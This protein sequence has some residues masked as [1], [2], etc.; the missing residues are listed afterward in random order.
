ML[1]T[2]GLAMMPL[3][4]QGKT[5]SPG[6]K[7]PWFDP[8][9]ADL[10]A[11]EKQEKGL[12]AEAR[13][14][15]SNARTVNGMPVSGLPTHAGKF[16]EEV[17]GLIRSGGIVGASLAI[18]VDHRLV[19]TRGYGHLCS[20]D[21]V[22]AKPT[23]P[24]FIGSITKTLCAMAGLTLVQAG[25]LGLDKKVV[26]ILPLPPL[27]KPGE[28]RQPEI[29]RVTVRMLME[30]TSG[31]F[32]VVE[33]LF[34]CPYY[35]KLGEVG[36]LELVHGDISQYDLVRRGM[37][38]PF[39]SKPGVEFNY[40]G[41]GLQVLGRIVESL[42]GLRLDQYISEKVLAPLG[43]KRHVSMSYLPPEQLAL[44]DA[45]KASKTDT[46]IPSPYVEAAGRC[47]SWAF[48]EPLENL[49]GNHW[50][51]ADACGA[52]MLSAVDL[53]RF[54]SSCSKLVHKDLWTAS[55]TP[56]V[57][58]GKDGKRG[59]DQHGLVWGVSTNAGH[60][61]FGHGGAWS[62]IRAFCESTWDDV[63]YAIV[64]SCDVD[65]AFNKLQEH[66]VQF[67]RSLKKQKAVDLWKSYGV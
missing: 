39:V 55:L 44:I 42:S 15:Q 47:S 57:V 40:S 35:G 13:E 58:R 43:V 59:P 8:N 27:L 52:S 37:A 46:F 9:Y 14:A 21:R 63:Q 51:Q 49:Y 11:R 45:G 5:P 53:L 1:G 38:K 25:K 67:G 28:V 32:N 4:G 3:I 10:P 26:D 29:D 64:A 2:A 22:H 65:D 24:G 17:A 6:Q 62:G 34:D 50:G 19:L 41:Q 48:A 16:D 33:E 54:V 30:H 66:V 61:Q 12:D 36:L 20:H 23:S 7:L 18:A 60:Y 56:P 31:L